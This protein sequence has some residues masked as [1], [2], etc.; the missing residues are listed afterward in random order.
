MG[1]NPTGEMPVDISSFNN[2]QSITNNN[3]TKNNIEQLDIIPVLDL[4]Q[5]P[6]NDNDKN[7]K[8]ETN[9]LI[10]NEIQK[11]EKSKEKE[12]IKNIKHFTTKE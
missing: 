9:I 3:I 1:Q 6:R 12:N 2:I 11:I 5:S 8:I 4:C 10:D 7:N